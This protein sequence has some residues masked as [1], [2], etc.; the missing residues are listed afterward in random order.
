MKKA[1]AVQEN[2]MK[3]EE[4]IKKIISEALEIPVEEVHL[5]FPSDPQF[6]DFTS[7]SAMVVGKKR[8]MNPLLLAETVSKKLNDES[9]EYIEDVVSVAPGFI[10]ISL[11][12]KYFA[13][14]LNEIINDEKYG[15]N[16]H[17]KGYRIAV[18]YTDPNPFKEFHIGHLVP[19]AV[20]ES[21]SRIIEMCGGEVA[22]MNYQGD[23]GLH[24]AMAVYGMMNEGGEMKTAKDLGRAYAFGSKAYREDEKA[25]GEIERINKV[26]YEE[27]D[28]AIMSH[29]RKGR[30]MSLQYFEEIYRVLGTKFDYYFFESETA[31]VG[32]K[33]VKEFLQR[34]VFEESEGAIIYRGE[35]HG[36]HNRVFVNKDGIPTYEAKEL[37]LASFKYEK[38]PYD[39]S[40]VITA[41]EINEYFKV[42]LSAMRETNEGLAKKTK[43]IGHGI[44]KLTTGKMSSRT[45]DVVSAISLIEEVKEK[46]K[47]HEKEP[48]EDSVREMI[49]ISAIKYSILKYAVG[50][51]MVFDM[52]KSVS[53]EGDSGPYLQYSAVRAKKIVDEGKKRGLSAKVSNSEKK[54][55]VEK[56]LARFPEVV[57]VAGRDSAPQKLVTYLIELAQAFNNFYASERV[58]D[59]GEET[60]HRLAI[61][62]AFHRVMKKGLW[63]LAIEVPERM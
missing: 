49:A 22:R 63:A 48:M 9:F 44:L 7:N 26:I 40:I 39:L 3:V 35:K 10:N 33:I 54:Y 55:A 45:G 11:S 15:E 13:E 17:V 62:T 31:P 56:F 32:E 51:D 24:V 43:H 21:I 5:D 20:G 59:A 4:K 47:E 58:L 60:E 12:K 34:G 28:N 27:S 1:S 29:Y 2:K 16:D 6:G 52:E 46:V 42:L 30:E 36:L 61:V 37:G 8:N 14:K 57:Y 18:E 41:N 23:K 50:K 25:K 19:N 38:F 53:L